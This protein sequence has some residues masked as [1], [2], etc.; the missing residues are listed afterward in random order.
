M[1][2]RRGADPR[3]HL[4]RRTGLGQRRADGIREPADRADPGLPARALPGGCPLLVQPDA[5]GRPG[6]VGGGGS[7]Q[8]RRHRAVRRGIPDACRRRDLPVGPRRLAGDLPRR[9][10]RR[11]LPRVHDRHHRQPR[12]PAPAPGCRRAVPHDRRTDPGGDVSGVSERGRLRRRPGR[13][14]REPAHQGAARV[15][16]GGVATS[17]VLA[18]GHPPRR[19]AADRCRERPGD[20]RRRADLPA[21]L[22]DGRQGWTDRVVPR[23]VGPDRRRRWRAAAVAGR[24]DRH[25]RPQARGTAARPGRGAVPA[26]GRALTGHRVHGTAVR[27]VGGG[28]RGLREPAD[29][30]LA[31]C[32]TGGVA[33]ARRLG[34]DDAS[35]RPRACRQGRLPP[36]GWP[37]SRG[38]PSTG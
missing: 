10:Q 26:A 11:L 33:G 13:N 25:H 14:V 28:I 29:L 20:R 31:G 37:G 1:G 6:A 35:R 16:A 36:R 2:P 5:P 23:R 7:V 8:R 17:R 19:S 38:W 15:H 34:G 4:L 30:H 21:G 12:R 18:A 3:R 9:R 24:D 32:A 22:S 27:G